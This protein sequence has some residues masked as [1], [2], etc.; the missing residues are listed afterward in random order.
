MNKNERA[1]KALSKKH[2]FLR[3]LAKRKGLVYSDL[4]CASLKT[5]HIREK[6]PAANGF[7]LK[8]SGCSGCRAVYKTDPC[9]FAE[10]VVVWTPIDPKEHKAVSH[11]T[12]LYRMTQE[13][14]GA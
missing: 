10:A 7:F 4:G 9:P 14:I 12:L 8:L 11:R 3:R 1:A 5:L 6:I 13:L 2:A